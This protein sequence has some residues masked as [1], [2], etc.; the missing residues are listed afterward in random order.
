[1]T[2]A[3]HIVQW[4]PLYEKSDT[5]KTDYMGW[6]SKQTKLVGL[7]IGRTLQ[8]G[9]PRNMELLG[10]WNVLE[11]LASQSVLQHRGW[12]V[13]SGQPLDFEGMSALVPTITADGFRTAC[14]WFCQ[15]RVGWL[16]E[17]EFTPDNIISRSKSPSHPPAS[18]KPL[19]TSPSHPPASGD[20][21]EAGG[22]NSA[23]DRERDR[24]STDRET[25][26]KNNGASDLSASKAQFA[27]LQAQIKELED[28]GSSASPAQRRDL[29]QKKA[30]RTELQ[31]RQAAGDFTPLAAVQT[32]GGAA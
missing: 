22:R 32:S 21:P 7:G 1:M 16:E 10:L 2:K 6:Y 4:H 25:G 11:I 15:D 31:Q 30:R 28:L 9:Y 14:E 19:G 27:A 18:G 12:L 23:T 29:R 20:Q 13:R 5:R 17:I 8:A 24:Q 3:F 26:K